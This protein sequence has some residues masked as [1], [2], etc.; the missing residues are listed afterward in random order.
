MTTALYFDESG[1]T[2]RQ[3]LDPLQKHFVLVSSRIDDGTANDILRTSFPNYQGDEFKFEKIWSRPRSRKRLDTFAKTVGVHAAKLYVWTIDKR[4]SLLIKMMEYLMEPAVYDAG[5]DWYSG[6]GSK[7]A[8]YAQFTLTYKAPPGLYEQ[9]LKAY[10]GFAYKPT[11]EK[12]FKLIADLGDLKRRAPAELEFFYT[13]CIGGAEDFHRHH[14]METFRDTLEIYVT[15]MLNSVGYWASK[16]LKGL[17]LNHD[18]SAGFFRQAELWSALTSPGVGAQFHPVQNGPAIAFPLPISATR[19]RRSQ[20]SASV[21]LCDVV[22]GLSAKVF[23]KQVDDDLLA[24]I[25][26]TGVAHIDTNGVGPGMDFPDG[27]PPRRIGK[28]AVDRMV[29]IIYGGNPAAYEK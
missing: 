12:R 13:A 24:S 11:E 22:A 18:E 25:A 9:T 3:L 23:S 15:S 14:Q 8:N 6:Y 1:Y 27:P 19:S 16:G 4:F 26:R 20:D 17:E 10:Y 28:D 5:L 21:Q 7:L 2:G 29:D